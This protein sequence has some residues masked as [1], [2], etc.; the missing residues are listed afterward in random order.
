MTVTLV[1]EAYKMM[2]D[3]HAHELK[4]SPKVYIHSDQGSQYLS[5]SFKQILSDDNFIQ[6]CSNRGNSQDNA[7]MESFFARL[8]TAILSILNLCPDFETAQRLVYGYIETFNNTPQYN[9]AA[10]SPK[11]FYIYTTTGVYPLDSYYGV[12]AS[13]LRS[14]SEVVD[15]ELKEKYEARKAKRLESK[16]R[17]EE[18]AKLASAYDRCDKDE[19]LVNRCISKFKK[20]I[21]I[22]NMQINKYKE[23]LEGIKK[24][25][26]FIVNAVD[27]IKELLRIPSNWRLYP[28]L[29][30]VNQMKAMF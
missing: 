11:E 26:L 23:I 6:S 17:R 19:I 1:E 2:M 12:K 22:S 14:L 27:S 30:Y 4:Q 29:D 5:T 10:L 28:E 9:L 24:G 3:N 20:T 7:P 25:K 21:E 15:K 8:K 13:E 16:K 18:R